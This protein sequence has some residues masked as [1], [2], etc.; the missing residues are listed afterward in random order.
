MQAKLPSFLKFKS[1]NDLIR[2]GRDN[3]G[4]YLVCQSDV[5]KSEVL[6]SLGICDDWS[7]ETDFTKRNNV[8]VHA[9]D[10]SV[11][12]RFWLKRT[13]AE[14]LKN[15]LGFYAFRKFFSYK[16]FFKGQNKHIKKF[17]GLDTR[18][19][20][21][22]TLSSILDD[23]D[24]ENIFLKID[25][26]S[27]EYRLLDTLVAYQNKI[28]GLAMELHDCDLHLDKIKDFVEKLDLNLVHVHANNY[29][30][31]R[32]EDGLPVV[33]EI[34]FSKHGDLADEAYLPHDLDM[35]ND[36]AAPEVNLSFE[37]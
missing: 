27:S 32:R 17:V 15:P 37:A 26:E 1:A 19:E 12:F 2:M 29:A 31:I 4:G 33:L 28:S 36:V 20:I 5:M 3:D 34:T 6:I 24:S 10:A 11:S 8:A 23:F 16:S 7:F 21:Y 30:P 9:Y 25:I 35:P 18:D 13:L 14:T 22:C